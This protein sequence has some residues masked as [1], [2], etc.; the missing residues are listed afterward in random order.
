MEL[1]IFVVWYL[2]ICFIFKIFLKKMQHG[3]LKYIQ[4]F[5]T[6]LTCVC[7]LSD[8]G[9]TW[10]FPWHL[11]PRW[12]PLCVLMRIWCVN[13]YNRHSEVF[14]D[15]VYADFSSSW[16]T[17]VPDVPE[18]QDSTLVCFHYYYVHFVWSTSNTG[19]ETSPQHY[20]ASTM[21]VIWTLWPSNSVLYMYI[22]FQYSV[23]GSHVQFLVKLG[24]YILGLQFLIIKVVTCY[25]Q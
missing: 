23:L 4:C 15:Y 25:F 13:F 22:S 19:G 7:K 1:S 10:M 2:Q 24:L 16:V 17:V 20:A 5:L 14:L 18:S 21:L 12:F 11:V 6:L 3:S 9:M 8:P